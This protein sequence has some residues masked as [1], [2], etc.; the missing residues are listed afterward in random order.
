[1]LRRTMF[2]RAT[3]RKV[4]F[5]KLPLLFFFLCLLLIA[6]LAIGCGG[7]SSTTLTTGCSGGPYD[8]VGDWTL[9]VSGSGNTSSGPGVINSSGLAVFFQT[10]TTVPSAGNTVVFPAI[11]GS[12]SFSG[13]GSAYGTQASGSQS[14]SDTVSGTIASATSMS[15]SISDG[16]TFT[17]APNSPLTGSVTALSGNTWAAQ[18][19]GTTN[20]LTWNIVMLPTG[21]NNSMTM[22]GSAT[23]HD[24]SIC[25]MSGTF[26]EETANSTNLNVFDISIASLDAGCPVGATVTGIGFESNT[27]YFDMNGNAA[28]TYFYA[29]PST[30]AAVLEIY[31][32]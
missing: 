3:L 2:R 23:N 10:T 21:T 26:T 16:N 14:A 8:V 15:G 6:A 11:T 4:L 30:T 18:F 32:P 27:D 1:M 12:C 31:Q 19:Q 7:N 28:G 17:L 24:G 25:H 13:A 20:P 9:T 29:V 22:T 5:R